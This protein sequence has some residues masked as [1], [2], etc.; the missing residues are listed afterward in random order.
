MMLGSDL[1]CAAT[2]MHLLTSNPPSGAVVVIMPNLEL[3]MKAARS[4]TFS[5]RP[6]SCLFLS[7]YLSLNQPDILAYEHTLDV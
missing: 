5:S 1:T 3:L 2:A 7:L 6:G 4:E